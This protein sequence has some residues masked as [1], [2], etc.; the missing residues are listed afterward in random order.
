MDLRIAFLAVGVC[1]AAYG[2]ATAEKQTASPS[3]A[4]ARSVE[5]YLT[6]SRLPLREED[7]GA[8]SVMAAD[9]AA[10]EE[11]MQRLT[12][13]SVCPPGGCRGTGGN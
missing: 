7:T 9:K 3:A 10:H 2:C 6:G 4:Q 1:A 11:A 5:R 13:G 8:H 12:S